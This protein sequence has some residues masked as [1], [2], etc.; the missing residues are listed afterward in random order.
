MLSIDCKYEAL[1]SNTIK[2]WCWCESL[3]IIF[4]K[5]MQ[6]WASV[7]PQ[8]TTVKRVEKQLQ[9]QQKR[10]SIG[11][12]KKFKSNKEIFR[13]DTEAAIIH[14]TSSYGSPISLLLEPSNTKLNA[15]TLTQGIW[16]PFFVKCLVRNEQNREYILIQNVICSFL[17]SFLFWEI[18]SIPSD[19]CN[20][21][22]F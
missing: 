9:V 20:Y 2:Y 18:I 21:W 17:N 22:M 4:W 5:L 13:K 6:S 8:K 15:P 1:F 10:F 19:I 16:T 7:E 14:Q 12:D 11:S 3:K